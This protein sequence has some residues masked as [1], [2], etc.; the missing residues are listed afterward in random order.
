MKS[1]VSA[2]V[3]KEVEGYMH[4]N[5]T[6]GNAVAM[7]IIQSARARAASRAAIKEVKRKKNVSHRLNLPGKLADCSSTD[8]NDSELFIVEGDSAG[9]SAKQGRDRKTQAILPLRGKVLNVEQATVKRVMDNKELQDVVSALGCGVG[10]SINPDSVR[11]GRIILLMD[12]DSDGHHI[13]TLLLTFFY[14]YMKPLINAGR[15]YI[16]QPPLYRVDVGKDTSWADDDAE[17]DRIVAEAIRRRPNAKPVI[18]RFKGLGEMMPKT[19]YETTLNPKK[20]RLLRVTI[21]PDQL[22]KTESTMGGL[23]GKDAKVR[24]DFIMENAETAEELDV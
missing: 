12:A 23:M 7:R 6:T 8:P 1:V 17:R 9:G 20:R 15:V 3:K 2:L 10:K 22:L 18:Q 24:F 13:A 4:N 5:P 19:L 21:P 16:A 11:Y 14:R